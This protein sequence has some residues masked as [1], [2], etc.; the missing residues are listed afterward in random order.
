MWLQLPTRGPRRVMGLN[1]LGSVPGCWGSKP[2][3][4]GASS[5]ESCGKSSS[6][7]IYPWDHNVPNRVLS[8]PWKAVIAETWA[9]VYTYVHSSSIHENWRQSR[10]YPFVEGWISKTWWA[11]GYVFLFLYF[12]LCSESQLF[13]SSW[14]WKCTESF[15]HLPHAEETKSLLLVLTFILCICVV[16]VICSV[17]IHALLHILCNLR[18]GKVGNLEM[19]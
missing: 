5:M 17:L 6:W 4:Q 1:L 10:P 16:Q 8:G 3:G 14:K 9:D 15:P 13:S 12:F 19:S 7:G 18:P 11:R 2:W